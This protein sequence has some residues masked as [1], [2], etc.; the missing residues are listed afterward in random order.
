MRGK[1]LIN[2]TVSF[3]E[4]SK[5]CRNII[6]LLIVFIKLILNNQILKIFF[7][8]IGTIVNMCCDKRKQFFRKLLFRCCLLI[9]CVINQCKSDLTSKQRK[10]LKYTQDHH[11]HKN[12]NNH[13]SEEDLFNKNFEKPAQLGLQ[14]QVATKILQQFCLNRTLEGE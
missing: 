5:I 3:L 12:S 4:G 13:H 10:P 7:S 2:F 14:D 11:F 1:N 6:L 8:V 9:V